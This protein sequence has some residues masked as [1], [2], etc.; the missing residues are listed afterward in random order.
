MSQK[1]IYVTFLPCTCPIGFQPKDLY[2]D[3][4][5]TSCTCVCDYKLHEYVTDPDC[6]PQTQ[7][8]ARKSNFWITH[9]E[10]SNL[11]D[12]LMYPHCPFD[13]CLSPS[14]TVQINL[15]LKNG[16]DGQCSNNRFGLLCE[17]CRPRFSLSLGSSQYLPC[18][19]VWQKHL[20]LILL[21]SLVSG[22]V[23]VVL[24]MVL[25]LTVAVGTLNG[26]IF[27]AN[28]IHAYNSAIFFSDDLLWQRFSLYS[29]HG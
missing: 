14:S 10:H 29:Y 19:A 23:L 15:N 22:I 1:R 21:V 3:V 28:I 24:I 27:Y 17:N 6:N 16:S 2:L 5:S 26:L 9:I 8:L 11:S 4:N 18:G 12:Y 7:T 20:A 13:Y 25:N